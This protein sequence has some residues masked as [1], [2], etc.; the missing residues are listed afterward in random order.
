MSESVSSDK[1]V[2][3]GSSAKSAS[4]AKAALKAGVVQPSFDSEQNEVE[5]RKYESIVIFA[6]R[7]SDN[8]LKEEIQKVEKILTAQSCT[9]IKVDDWGRKNT[10]YLMKKDRAGN[11]VVFNYIT[12]NH[13]APSVLGGLLRLSDVVNKFQT[14]KINSRKRKFQGNPN[15]KPGDSEFFDDGDSFE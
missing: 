13:E 8:Q 7:L 9:E 2:N 12:L 11:Y 6:S 14:H 15:R 4:S 10:S 3:Y 5:V 1:S